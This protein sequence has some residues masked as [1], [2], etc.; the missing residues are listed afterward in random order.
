MSS[1]DPSRNPDGTFKTYAEYMSGSLGSSN[2]PMVSQGFSGVMPGAEL[3]GSLDNRRFF[4]STLERPQQ[5]PQQPTLSYVFSPPISSALLHSRS[6]PNIKKLFSERDDFH[7]LLRSKYGYVKGTPGSYEAALERYIADDDENRSQYF[8]SQAERIQ[9]QVDASRRHQERDNYLLQENLR[10][11]QEFQQGEE[12]PSWQDGWNDM[13]RRAQ[14]RANAFFNR[15]HPYSGQS[16]QRQQQRQQRSYSRAGPAEEPQAGHRPKMTRT[17]ALRIMGVPPGS[18]YDEV[19][20]AF[21]K[22]ALKYHPDKTTSDEP[23]VAAAKANKYKKIHKA[24]ELLT[25]ENAN[26]GDTDY[27]EAEMSRIGGNTIKRRHKKHKHKHAKKTR[28]KRPTKRRSKT[29]N[30]TYRKTHRNTTKRR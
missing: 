30:N 10:R 28:A 3:R 29:R 19:K 24:Y 4:E 1:G 27:D 5:T 18:S 21:R 26:V 8:K 7:E 6:Q 12:P 16:Q 20:K 2:K 14:E 23:N 9:H 15:S 25:I 11:N 17:K 13:Y 22:A